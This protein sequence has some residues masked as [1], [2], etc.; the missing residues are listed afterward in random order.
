[1]LV[2][3]QN[4]SAEQAVK[5]IEAKYQEAAKNNDLAF[6]KAHLAA[7]YQGVQFDGSTQDDLA[8]VSAREKGVYSIA[9]YKLVS[10]SIHVIG[11]TAVV[12]ECMFI[13]FSVNG[14]SK[15]GDYQVTRVWQTTDDGWKVI[16][17]QMTPRVKACAVGK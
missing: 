17:L 7:G 10:Q 4:Q 8:L 6:I 16:S 9:S 13:D 14:A 1:M 5:S 3:G 2:F 11:P 15:A 12:T